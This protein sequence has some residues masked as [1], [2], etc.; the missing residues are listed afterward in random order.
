M[1]LAARSKAWVCGHL[2][3]GVAGSNPA[4]GAWM[5]VCCECSLFSGTH[6]SEGPITRPDES[7]RVCVCVTECVQ[8]QQ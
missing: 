4:G 7:Y 1:A 5:S 8:T 2:L 3:L 6:L